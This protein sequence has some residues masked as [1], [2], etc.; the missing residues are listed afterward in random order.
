[1]SSKSYKSLDPKRSLGQNF[2]SDPWWIQRIVNAFGLEP[3]DTVLEIGPGKGVL[4][5]ELLKTCGR[6]IAVEID[7]R[8]VEY[9]GER[10]AGSANLELVHQDFLKYPLSEVLAGQPVR[11]IGNLPYHIT[12]SIIGRVLDEIRACQA[13]SG[14]HARITSFD[15]MIQKEVG[16]RICST[17]GTKVYGVLSVL[18]YMLCDVRILLDVPPNAFYPRPK[19][20]SSI[21]RFRPLPAPRY[22]ITDWELFR[23]VVR[24]AFNQ[25]RKMLRNSLLP[26][27]DLLPE[28]FLSQTGLD[29]LERRPEQLS[30]LEFTQL[31]NLVI[32]A[33]G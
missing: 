6:L 5:N 32:E 20:T 18:A 24:A 7:D 16:D 23:K 3:Q 15:I 4:T 8:M 28:G 10:F 1:M 33:R 14:A 29:W 9:L 11:V 22:Q 12:S 30:P 19:V 2:L 17:H 27:A 21:L 25:R 26:L 31:A 13:D